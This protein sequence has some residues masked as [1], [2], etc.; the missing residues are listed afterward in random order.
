[1]SFCKQ[2]FLRRA[3]EMKGKTRTGSANLGGQMTMRAG[4][5]GRGVTNALDL[6][7]MTQRWSRNV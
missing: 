1:M 3:M 2:V 7:G 4:M 5:L 6:Y